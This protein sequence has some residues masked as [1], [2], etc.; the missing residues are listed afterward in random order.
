MTQYERLDSLSLYQKQEAESFLTAF[1]FKLCSC[2]MLNCNLSSCMII[3]CR[4]LTWQCI[5]ILV[6]CMIVNCD[7]L[8]FSKIRFLTIMFWKSVLEN[9]W[10][11]IYLTHFLQ[12]FQ[13]WSSVILVICRRS[14]CVLDHHCNRHSEL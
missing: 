14:S 1:C 10:S 3:N 2:I 11:W 8:I 5:Q 6:S 13:F 7:L 12:Y 9:Q 4:L